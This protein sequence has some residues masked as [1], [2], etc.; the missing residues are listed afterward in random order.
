MCLFLKDKSL[1][2]DGI[3]MSFGV[4]SVSIFVPELEIDKDVFYQEFESIKNRQVVQEGLDKKLRLTVQGK[5]QG[6]ELT[7]EYTQF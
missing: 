1:L 6:E 3:V 5:E 2:I 4:N 7:L